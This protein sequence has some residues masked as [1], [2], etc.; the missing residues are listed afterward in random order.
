MSRSRFSD[1][2]INGILKEH[3]VG[4]SAAMYKALREICDPAKVDAQAFADQSALVA[5]YR[6]REAALAI[7]SATATPPPGDAAPDGP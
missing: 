1:E 2:Q 6:G 3:Q 7:G 4:M 5:G